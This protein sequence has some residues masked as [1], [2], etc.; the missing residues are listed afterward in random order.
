MSYPDGVERP[1]DVERAV[2]GSFG[3]N[4]PEG[5]FNLDVDGINE[6][7]A[8]AKGVLNAVP[9]EEARAFLAKASVFFDT[10]AKLFGLGLTV[11][12]LPSQARIDA[13]V[14]VPETFTVKLS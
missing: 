4:K 3:G 11:T 9:P 12:V 8:T 14:G 10:L 1:T 5:M 13:G 6:L 2:M 7:V